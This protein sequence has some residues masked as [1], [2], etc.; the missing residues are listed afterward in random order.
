MIWEERRVAVPNNLCRASFSAAL[1]SAAGHAKNR[2][3]IAARNGSFRPALARAHSHG[4]IT[5]T[6]KSVT[7]AKP[8]S[9]CGCGIRADFNVQCHDQNSSRSTCKISSSDSASS[10][11][12]WRAAVPNVSAPHH[13]ANFAGKSPAAS[14]CAASASRRCG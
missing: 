9:G 12:G 11:E 13:R 5:F 2:R 3:A 14:Q 1:S 8:S 7:R 4:K 6:A 10:R